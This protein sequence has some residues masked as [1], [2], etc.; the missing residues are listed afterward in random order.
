MIQYVS[1]FLLMISPILFSTRM[2]VGAQMHPEVNAYRQLAREMYKLG[3]DR[4]LLEGNGRFVWWVILAV[5]TRETRWPKKTDTFSCCMFFFLGH[6]MAHPRNHKR[7]SS[8]QLQVGLRD[9]W[10]RRTIPCTWVSQKLEVVL[11]DLASGKR[12]E[13]WPGGVPSEVLSN[14]N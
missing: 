2:R 3:W 4:V 8:S 5:E 10:V 7:V 13:R 12:G 1:R 11:M 14:H 9:C 6:L